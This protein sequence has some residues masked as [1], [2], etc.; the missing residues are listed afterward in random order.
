MNPKAVVILLAVLLLGLAALLLTR[1][2]ASDPSS[3][4]NSEDTSKAIIDSD[5]L[6]SGISSIRIGAG[7]NGF[8]PLLLERSAGR[9]QV[10]EPHAFPANTEPIDQLLELIASLEG[11]P[12]DKHNAFTPDNPGLT[13]SNG[14]QFITLYFGERIGAGRASVTIA[15]GE[16]ISNWIVDDALHE[17]FDSYF[18]RG[19][20][21][22]FYA[23]K[24][25]PLLMP[26]YGRIE[27]SSND[28]NSA[29]IQ[30]IP[31]EWQVSQDQAI[32][33]ALTEQLGE[34]PGVATFFELHNS[35]KPHVHIEYFRAVE[36]AQ[37]GLDRPLISVRF[38][39]S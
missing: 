30:S 37:Y 13:I 35:I 28:S 18:E 21:T 14:N 1:P 17:V 4:D 8:Q 10:I 38:V 5:L 24:I 9:W 34:Y 7:L 33:P 19:G 20:R 36:L 31:G 3:K 11:E 16:A 25:D 15:N 23:T 29:L 6:D 2:G 27:L 39:P 12:T 32:A 26:E 22:I